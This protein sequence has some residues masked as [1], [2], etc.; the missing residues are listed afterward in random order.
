MDDRDRRPL[1][2]CVAE[3]PSLAL[4]IASFLSDGKHVTR[5]GHL[6][7]HEFARPHEGALCD[8]RVTAVTGHVLSIDFPARFQS[9]DVDPSSLFDAPVVKKEASKGSRV[10]EHLEREA[11]GAAR[12]I[13]WLDCDREGENI[14]FEVMD[15]CVPVMR[16][17]KDP[18]FAPAVRRAKFSAVT[19]PQVEAAMRDLRDPDVHQARAV[20]ARAELD[21]KI[22]VAFTRFQTNHFR[23]KF[24]GLDSSVVSYGPCQTP[25]LAFVAARRREIAA[26]DP[27]PFWRV[28]LS[29]PELFREEASETRAEEASASETREK[30]NSNT[31]TW[32][33]PP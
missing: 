11:R 33:R 18:R 15:A 7:V 32:R 17:V 10:V 28:S 30:K 31:L 25:T 2:V 16:S 4:S 1:V 21:L 9:W 5:R 23:N 29:C 20:D 19:K 6:D 12:L 24:S 22:G 26:H 13:L 3:K 14:C 8:F 27:E